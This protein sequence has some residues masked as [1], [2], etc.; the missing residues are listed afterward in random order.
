MARYSDGMRVFIVGYS[1]YFSVQAVSSFLKLLIYKQS[2]RETTSCH[3]ALNRRSHNSIFLSLCTHLMQIGNSRRC[4]VALIS[5]ELCGF[6]STIEI[7]N[8]V[9]TQVVSVIA[10]AMNKTGFATAQ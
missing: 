6:G 3:D 4:L 5:L 1:V 9:C 7:R 10:C 2:T 8:Q